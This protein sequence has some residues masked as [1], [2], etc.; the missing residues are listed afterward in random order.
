MAGTQ[1]PRAAG[2]L[3]PGWASASPGAVA[4][5]RHAACGSAHCSPGLARVS[6]NCPTLARRWPPSPRVR[7][8]NPG[9]PV[10]SRQQKSPLLR[11][12]EDGKRSVFRSKPAG[13]CMGTWSGTPKGCLCS[14]PQLEQKAGPTPT[15][16]AG[17]ASHCSSP[18][19]T[20]QGEQRGRGARRGKDGGGV[21]D[22][23]EPQLRSSKEGGGEDGFLWRLFLI[24]IYFFSLLLC[25]Q[26]YPPP[27]TTIIIKREHFLLHLGGCLPAA[28]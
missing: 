28:P 25:W 19:P 14:D 8:G 11:A 20:T 16:D 17:D 23:P 15:P 5:G 10:P 1:R 22:G 21:G 6:L 13:L 7:T 2:H 18:W 3:T 26:L 9:F 12:C 4:T 27:Q 24:F